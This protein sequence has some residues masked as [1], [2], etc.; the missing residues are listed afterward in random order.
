MGYPMNQ[1]NPLGEFWAGVSAKMDE[2]TRDYESKLDKSIGSPYSLIPEP[3]RAA[4]SCRG[5]VHSGSNRYVVEGVDDGGVYCENCYTEADEE[6]PTIELPSFD[7]LFKEFRADR[8]ALWLLASGAA[9]VCETAGGALV[10][11]GSRLRT[12]VAG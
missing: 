12:A 5:E 9:T 1:D 2:L 6:E 7:A 3:F 10:R 8:L 4:S 11:L